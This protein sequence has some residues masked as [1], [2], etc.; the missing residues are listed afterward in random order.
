M[1]FPTKIIFPLICFLLSCTIQAQNLEVIYLENASFE[2][3]AGA[4]RTPNGWNNCGQSQETPPDIQPYG[5]FSVT[6][7]AFDGKTYIG[8]VTRSYNT[9]ESISQKLSRPLI[10]GNCYNFSLMACKSPEYISP[11]RNNM[12]SPTNFNRGVVLKIYGANGTCEKTEL[13]D[14]LDQ[15]VEN[16]EWKKFDFQFKP[17]KNDYQ[18]LIIEAYYKTP[19]LNYYNGNVLIDQA[20]EIYS[21]SIP[22]DASEEE[23]IA[24]KK[25]KNKQIDSTSVLTKT[26]SSKVALVI[27]TSSK[28]LK[29]V[30][31]GSFIPENIKAENLNIGDKF[32]LDKLY[33]KADSSSINK[34]SELILQ[35]LFIFLS[36]NPQ[37]AL[38]VGGHTNSLP[39]DDFCDKLSTER[40]KSV[41]FYLKKLGI[42][43]QRMSYVGYGKRRPIAD[44]STKEG[45][46]K[47]Q[48][49]EFIITDKKN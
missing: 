6:R 5:G 25:D 14:E 2:G 39:N 3:I 17:Q 18:Y 31:K 36:N 44:N 29:I 37:F 46:R 20:S 35:S 13:L 23:I 9:W 43:S 8:L 27:N 19:T 33:F 12:S 49:V 16:T 15:A 38:E 24:V 32:R 41:V 45:Q 21:C 30:D 4:G 42:N 11:T 10:K 1:F 48:R 22:T 47:N 40:A 34:S 28:K 7:P 26:D